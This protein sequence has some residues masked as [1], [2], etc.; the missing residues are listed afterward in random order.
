MERSSQARA[1]FAKWALRTIGSSVGVSVAVFLGYIAFPALTTPATLVAGLFLCLFVVSVA[2]M[3]FRMAE[4]FLFRHAYYRQLPP[5]ERKA[6]YDAELRSHHAPG[7]YVRLG[8]T[9][10]LG[11]VLGVFLVATA[12]MLIRPFPGD[13]HFALRMALFVAAFVVVVA[14]FWLLPRLRR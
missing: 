6:A 13:E 1:S 4:Y 8:R 3:L 14:G 12:V 5:T 7:W 11:Y 2:M 10:R 9:G